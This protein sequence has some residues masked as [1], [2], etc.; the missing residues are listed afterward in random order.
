MLNIRVLLN[1][2][3]RTM[4]KATQKMIFKNLKSINFIIVIS[5]V[6]LLVFSSCTGANKTIEESI[7][8]E[9]QTSNPSLPSQDESSKDQTDAEDN[10]PPVGET[11]QKPSDDSVKEPSEI[12]PPSEDP[13]NGKE[14]ELPSTPPSQS[15]NT[16]TDWGEKNPVL[17]HVFLNGIA[18]QETV[19]NYNKQYLIYEN[20][21]TLWYDVKKFG[22]DS[23]L[24]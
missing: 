10:N 6:I 9:T 2:I 3:I 5:L 20:E 7:K 8:H 14:D 1:I 19:L 15:D 18:E 22:G 24:C 17:R 13:D 4:R 23:H 12:T 21:N 16:N 11:G